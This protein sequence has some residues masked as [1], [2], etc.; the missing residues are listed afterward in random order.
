MD[1]RLVLSTLASV[2]VACGTS[3]VAMDGGTDSSAPMDA[4]M[5]VDAMPV[6]TGAKDSGSDTAADCG[7]VDIDD[8]GTCDPVSKCSADPA[9]DAA[10]CL[11]ILDGSCANEYKELIACQRKYTICNPSTCKTDPIKTG[12]SLQ[13]NCS[14]QQS[15]FDTCN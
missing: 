3:M 12:V 15:N 2:V 1:R 10:G 11:A 7:V 6:D 4:S 9:P 14:N 5:D 8:A 13:Q